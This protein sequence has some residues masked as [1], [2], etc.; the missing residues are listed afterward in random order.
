[1]ATM[2]T[3]KWTEYASSSTNVT[4]VG[5][6]F[7]YN[8][9]GPATIQFSASGNAAGSV[10]QTTG[11]SGV[12]QTTPQGTD[13]RGNPYDTQSEMRVALRNGQS[14]TSDIKFKPDATP[15]DPA[16]PDVEVTGVDFRIL[17]IEN[18]KTGVNDPTTS[19]K[20]TIRAYDANGNPVRIDVTAGSAVTATTGSANEAVIQPKAGVTTRNWGD[21]GTNPGS[22][23]A[24]RNAEAVSAL[25][26]I[27]GPVAR[28]EVTTEYTG[29]N[30]NGTSYPT[31]TDINY[32]PKAIVCFAAG[33]MIDTSHGPV[34]VEDL[35]VGDLVMTRD[36]GLQPI[37]WID[38]NSLTHIPAN[39]RP[40]RI[41]AG[42]LG[43]DTPSTDLLVS[44]QHRILVRSAIAQKMFG[45]SEVLVA[46]KQLLQIDGIDLA[47]DL[48]EVTYV[49]FLFDDHQIVFSNG[50]ETESLY[51]GPEALD[52]V[53]PAA[54]DEIFALFPELADRDDAPAAAR[55]LVSGR[56]GRRLAVR[57]AQHRKPL[58][59]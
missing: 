43:L 1:M 42:A 28:I 30:A 20:I 45:T 3:F 23:T 5:G 26:K 33:T 41:R 21:G 58:V 6:G 11:S 49:H 19:A 38:Q 44:P 59:M 9:Q 12:A 14:Q 34:A 17:R 13:A 57:H 18:G 35:A 27:A 53:G 32:F 48:D 37:R 16:R 25:I 56:M 46:A 36:S 39:F 31:F 2:E 8:D 50:T 4:P 10:I 29:T 15:A 7:S 22:A 52:S 24:I 54:R 47:H 55:P 51:T 40:V